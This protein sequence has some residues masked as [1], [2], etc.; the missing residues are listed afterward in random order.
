MTRNQVDPGVVTVSEV[1][2]GVAC[3]ELVFWK[4][5]GEVD[6]L[7][8]GIAWVVSGLSP[9]LLLRAPSPKVALTRALA[10]WKGRRRLVRPLDGGG[11]ALVDE[12]DT[13][14]TLEWHTRCHVNL[15]AQGKIVVS[16]NSNGTSEVPE[17]REAHE[18]F[19]GTLDHS[20]VSAWLCKLLEHC[21]AVALRE[22]GG[23]YF[24]PAHRA[25][26]WDLM[27]GAVR[28][29]SAHVVYN[30]P[31]LRTAGAVE[32]IMDAMA[33]EVSRVVGQIQEDLADGDL[34][35]RAKQT[36]QRAAGDLERKLGEFEQLLG[37]RAQVLHDQIE[38]L[39]G[40]LAIA[41]LSSIE[42]L[43]MPGM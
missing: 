26:L 21:D 12:R 13:A 10:E 8:L 20:D 39:R 27:V 43:P 18:R 4:L 5:A 9:S 32:A 15:D 17:L 6:A 30:L 29:V 7:Q 3:G 41:H 22:G 23:V 24:V 11:Y 36:R 2:E 16:A 37:T 31:A 1:P 19:Q 35:E 28:K 33:A 40:H 25:A 42:Q 34:G 14:G 38:S